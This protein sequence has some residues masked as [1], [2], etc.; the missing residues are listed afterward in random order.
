MFSAV[1][2]GLLD[3]LAPRRCPGCDVV[4]EWGCV[5]FCTACEP[6]LDS[7]VSNPAL[8]EFG[9]PLSEAIRRLK[10]TRR[11]D[12]LEP[13][14]ELLCQGAMRHVGRV[15]VVVP[16]P[17]H[18]ARFRKRGFNQSELL[19]VPLARV[20]GVPLHPHRIERTR[21]TPP[22]ASFREAQ[23]EDNVRGAFVAKR[24]A[25]RRRVLLV[26]DVRTTG[27]TLRSATGALHRAGASQVRVM[28]LAGVR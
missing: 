21:N 20:L 1:G 14:A 8:Y 7:L 11:M 17:L 10:Y 22:Q 2:R 16:V 27:A 18:V 5:G 15:D 23:R 13:L 9:G 26:D 25:S 12:L 19:A 4:L 3:L 6:L 28:T 24:D